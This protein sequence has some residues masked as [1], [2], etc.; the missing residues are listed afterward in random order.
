VSRPF[1]VLSLLAARPA[2]V[3]R[4]AA[5]ARLQTDDR[6]ALEY[7]A[8]G[9]I[10]HWTSGGP[11]G[12]SLAALSPERWKDEVGA[13]WRRANAAD[14]VDRGGMLLAA[15][16]PGLAYQSF[17]R[18]AAL[19]P[20][21]RAAIDGLVRAAPSAEQIPSTLARLRAQVAADPLDAGAATG[22]SRLL[23]GVG[24][25]DEAA[26][27]ARRA[28]LVHPADA[29][30]LEQWASV[31]ADSR[32][33]DGLRDIVSQLMQRFPDR[34]GALYYAGTLRMLEG[35]PQEAAGLA[36]RAAAADPSHAE[37]WGLLGASLASIGRTAEANRAFESGV[38]ANPRDPSPYANLGLVA[39]GA[40]K[41]AEAS[42]WFAESLVADP[43]YLAAR[44]GLAAALEAQGNHE[45]ARRVR[46]AT[47]GPPGP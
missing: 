5:G 17:A 26:E 9:A 30:P 22:L 10:Y 4:Y 18:A 36:Q 32:Q 12:Q 45:R 19:A 46:Q 3:A 2:D 35:R 16:A 14:W 13:M 37:T 20:G 7:S 23:A 34:P 38:R 21:D 11:A 33:V 47:T 43:S 1:S 6:L 29:G 44:E 42:R 25:W 27:T 8:P 31:L 40:G 24:E 41:A 39:L 15:D 28:S